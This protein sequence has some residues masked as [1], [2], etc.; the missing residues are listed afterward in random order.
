MHTLD[1]AACMPPPVSHVV[2]ED[3]VALVNAW[4]ATLGSYS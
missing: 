3:G 4:I 2:D 1:T